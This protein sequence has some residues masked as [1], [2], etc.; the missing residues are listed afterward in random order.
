MILFFYSKDRIILNKNGYGEHFISVQP[1]EDTTYCKKSDKT[2]KS[3][4][5]CS[6]YNVKI[7]LSG[8]T[9]YQS[10]SKLFVMIKFILLFFINV[11]HFVI[12]SR[13]K[14]IIEG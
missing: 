12:I 5:C 9:M 13:T 6:Y 1:R 11:N 2:Y 10:I 7:T 14:G 8:M 4:A 3:T